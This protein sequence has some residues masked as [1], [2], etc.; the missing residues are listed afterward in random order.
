MTPLISEENSKLPFLRSTDV[1]IGALLVEIEQIYSFA[2]RFYTSLSALSVWN[3]N[4][5]SY[6][7]KV[8]KLWLKPFRRTRNVRSLKQRLPL[9]NYRYVIYL[10]S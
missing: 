8:L 2:R 9:S 10:I 1:R 4:Q 3:E 6:C 7:L 5:I